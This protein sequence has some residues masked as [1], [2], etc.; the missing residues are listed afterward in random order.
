M[1]RH[2]VVSA[3]NLVEGG[4]LTILLESLASAA[5]E[6]GSEWDITALVHD[7]RLVDIPRVRTIAFPKSKSSWFR[8]V[9]TEWHDFLPLS[10]ELKADLWLSLHDITP[11]VVA[12]RQA[13]YCH[14]SSPF[15][16]ASW[17]EARLEPK[18]KLFTMFYLSLY[19]AFIDRNHTVI[20]Q[21]E[22][23]RDEF[24]RHTG[25]SN[26]LVAHPSTPVA[27]QPDMI[28]RRP[29]AGRP[30][31]LL[32]PSLARVFKNM[33]TLCAAVA[34]LP[35]DVTDRIDLRLTLDGPDNAYAGDLLDR[36]GTTRGISFIGRQP[37]EAMQQE[38]RDCDI[39]LF[40]SRLESWGLPISEAKSYGKPLIVADLPYARETVATYSNV[41]FLPADD[42]AAWAAA[43]SQA[44]AGE[45][46]PEGQ[47]AKLPA[48]P[49]AADWPQ[50]WEKLT[51][52]L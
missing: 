26:I 14:N 12:R 3:V 42:P 51:H 27:K 15:Y 32:Y 21:Q 20:V 24:H 22:W 16:R 5:E 13:V 38:Y 47:V 40:P 28:L 39:V 43:I 4:T 35:E 17:R 18:F 36:Y 33:E 48:E 10:K 46:Q 25:H 31:R 44:V 11:R 7:T 37:R 2:L 49:F 45:W 8:R 29:E 30:L 23:L 19:R 34:M 6:L 41:R 1:R 9:W 50:F 52:G